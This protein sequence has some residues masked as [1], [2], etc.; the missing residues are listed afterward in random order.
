[1]SD[2][3]STSDFRKCQ[4]DTL[5]QLCNGTLLK[6]IADNEF[7]ENIKC[8]DNIDI[9]LEQLKNVVKEDEYITDLFYIGQQTE[10]PHHISTSSEVDALIHEAGLLFGKLESK[11]LVITCARSIYDEYSPPEDVDDIQEK[12]LGILMKCFVLGEVSIGCDIG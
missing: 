1:M 12:V 8:F 7:T 9:K 2:L 10:L 4:L 3:K 11:P 6:N 5:T